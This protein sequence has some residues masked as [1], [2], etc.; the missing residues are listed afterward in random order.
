M[1]NVDKQIPN[2]SSPIDE[3][4]LEI[5]SSFTGHE[6]GKHDFENCCVHPIRFFK[7]HVYLTIL[8]IT[9]F[10]NCSR[11]GNFTISNAIKQDEL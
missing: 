2:E 6:D 10:Y 7:F 5:A 4:L 3:Q 9:D 1:D 8:N 11:R